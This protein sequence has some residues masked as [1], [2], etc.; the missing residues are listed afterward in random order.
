MKTKKIFIFMLIGT[1]FLLA[2]CSKSDKAPI[3]DVDISPVKPSDNDMA[4]NDELVIGS[5]TMLSEG[6]WYGEVMEGVRQA[7][8]DLNITLIEQASEG[9][10]EAEQKQ[11]HD[12]IN[13][14]VDAIVICPITSDKS[15]ELLMEAEGAGIPAITWN[16]V[17]DADVTASVCVDSN[18]LGGDTGNYLAEYIRTYNLNG[19]KMALITNESY[20]I[21]VARCDGFKEAIKDLE[22]D[23]SV[24]VVKE[25]LAETT[26][27][28]IQ[29]VNEIFAEYPDIDII[30]CWNQT[31]LLA[32]IDVA[33]E[34]GKSDLIIMGTDMSVSI[35]KD[36]L[37]D[38]TDILAVTTQLPYN[39]GYKAVVNAVQ[40]AKGAD[41]EKTITIPPFTYV[42]GDTDGLEQYIDSHEAFAQ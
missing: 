8:S 35:A 7:A 12:F 42:K 41:V 2:G 13:D 15:G 5:I 14:G 1:M 9:D 24:A 19:L 33:K 31:S 38:S 23:G 25:V 28:T 36:M 34:K 32:C 26:E 30:W 20:T 6:E 16:T 40:A 4:G 22:N 27:E 10:L 11:V 21:G 18:A 17:V 3:V 29:A 37:E 39:M